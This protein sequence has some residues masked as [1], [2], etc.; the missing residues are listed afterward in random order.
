MHAF[1]SLSPSL[2]PKH[3]WPT[4]ILWLTDVLG[5]FNPKIRSSEKRRYIKNYVVACLGGG[6][7]P[8]VVGAFQHFLETL[9]GKTAGCLQRLV[10]NNF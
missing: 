5:P 8:R 6:V 9:E 3:A 7:V 10:R 1:A 2:L 4:A